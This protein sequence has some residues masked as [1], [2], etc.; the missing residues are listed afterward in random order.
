MRNT[1]NKSYGLTFF[2]QV[3]AN[4]YVGL[5]LDAS[6]TITFAMISGKAFI[7]GSQTDNKT[8][9]PSVQYA[10]RTF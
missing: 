6:D 1:V 2:E 5:A 3:N 8:Q 9:D 4:S 10:K 7:Y